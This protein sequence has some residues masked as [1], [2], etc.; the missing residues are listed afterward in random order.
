MP[1]AAASLYFAW[2]CF[3][4]FMSRP[5][6]VAQSLASRQPL[7]RD[8]FAARGL[9]AGDDVADVFDHR[10]HVMGVGVDDGVAVAGDC[11]MAFPEDQIAALQ[12]FGF[13]RTQ[14]A[15]ETRLLHVAVARTAGAGGVE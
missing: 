8:N 12:P 4:D 15:A 14:G 10:C 9:D 13:R 5:C 2:G 7:D 3:R 6:G 1:R 11:D